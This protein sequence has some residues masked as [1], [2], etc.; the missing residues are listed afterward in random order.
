MLTREL[1]IATRDNGQVIPDRLTV[2]SHQAYLG[3]AEKMIEVY[4]QGMGQARGTIHRSVSG[5]LEDD[6]NCP[7]RRAGAF[8]KLLDEWCEFDRGKPK[9]TSE[10]R[11]QVFRLAATYHPLVAKV[12]SMLEHSEQK[13][14]QRIAEELGVGWPE[15]RGRLFSD[16]IENHTLRTFHPPVESSDLLSR[17]NVAQ[18]QAALLDAVSIRIDAT[19]DWKMILRYAKLAGLMHRI[20][21][22]ESG[23]RF[24][25]DGAA[26]VLRSTHRYG[27]AMAKFLP[28]LIACRGWSMTATMKHDRRS[29]AS[30]MG[31]VR[32]ELNDRSGLKS[33][34][35]GTPES[36]SE[37][38]RQLIAAWGEDRQQGWRLVR[39]GDIL[40]RG[41]RVF[42]PDFVLEH[43]DGRRM[44]V[45]IA[46]YWTPEYIA[47]KA[48]VLREFSDVPILVAVPRSL[49]KHWVNMS[50]SNRHRM[51]EYG[52]RLTADGI[53]GA[54]ETWQSRTS[55]K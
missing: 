18:T 26:S 16:L 40:H 31:G 43:L 7:V 44:L 50:W 34:V 6:A 53:L 4:R 37:V 19:A 30:W 11:R 23:Y 21:R 9:T 36:D 32:L 47:H 42:M 22:T 24:E 3:Y 49:A 12:E 54:I 48:E 1:A 14:K 25:F 28:G 29:P 5:I 13:V 15:L 17:Y 33:S 41:Q 8:C 2:H 38:E 20:T 46:G 55:D 51:F 10:L 35:A 52:K 45:E 27:A 39:E